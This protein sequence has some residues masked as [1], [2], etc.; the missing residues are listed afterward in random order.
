MG[1][2]GAEPLAGRLGDAR[3]RPRLMPPRPESTA[4]DAIISIEIAEAAFDPHPTPASHQFADRRR[5]T[6]PEMFVGI[7]RQM[8]VSAERRG[9]VKGSNASAGA[10]ARAFAGSPARR[11]KEDRDPT[12]RTCVR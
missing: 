10:S 1:S 7:P 8:L 11:L 5:V 12:W 3:F 9:K 2:R 6:F 4:T